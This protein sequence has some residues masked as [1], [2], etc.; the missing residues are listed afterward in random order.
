[1]SGVLFFSVTTTQLGFL[2]NH[3]KLSEVLI[4][5]VTR[6]FGVWVQSKRFSSKLKLLLN[7]ELGGAFLSRDYNQML[8]LLIRRWN[9]GGVQWRAL[10][11]NTFLSCDYNSKNTFP[12]S[13]S[14]V[15]GANLSCDKTVWSVSIEQEVFPQNSNS[16]SIL[17]LGVLFF[18]VTTTW[19][20]F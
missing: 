3:S 9:V 16:C 17:N 11:R 18:S 14:I 7:S 19:M 20:I 4:C 15:G 8:Q 6:Q 1:M 2:T 10:D 5:R 12:L 13:F